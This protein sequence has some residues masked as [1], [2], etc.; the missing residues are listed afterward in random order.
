MLP[1][2]LLLLQAAAPGEVAAFDLRK[3]KE[4]RAAER[5]AE[6]V[7]EEIVVCAR[8]DETVRHRVE[9][10]PPAPVE[11]LLPKAEMRLFGDV[12]GALTTEGATLPDGTQSNRAMVKLKVPF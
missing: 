10:L 1:I 12:T 5:C 9:M 6:S 4:S 11:L 8:P 2:A 7:G 3:L